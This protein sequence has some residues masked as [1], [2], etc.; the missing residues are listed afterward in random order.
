MNNDHIQPEARTGRPNTREGE[1][2]MKHTPG[3]WIAEKSPVDLNLRANCAFFSTMNGSSLHTI[4]I[5]PTYERQ[6]QWEANV[7]LIAAAPKLLEA[8]RVFVSCSYTCSP[9]INDRGYA[10][11]EAYL[12]RAL[13]IAREVIKEATGE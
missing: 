8:L 7:R 9:E 6:E 13:P 5:C 2:E 10:W 4:A 1:S 12:D 11:S 3:P